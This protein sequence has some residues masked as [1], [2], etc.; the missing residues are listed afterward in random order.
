M[1][2]NKILEVPK[3]SKMSVFTASLIDYLIKA[4][5][6]DVITDDEMTEVCGKDT[7]PNKSGYGNLKS[8]LNYLLNNEG[9]VFERIRGSDAIKC[10]DS[11][12]TV[13]SA[14]GDLKGMH[15]R[16][17]KVRKKTMTVDQTQLSSEDIKRLSAVSAQV[18][19]LELISKRDTFKKL[20]VK[21]LPKHFKPDISKIVWE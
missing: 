8:A 16:A 20:V 14:E 7:R 1:E 21:E 6:G 17:K 4:E 19:F 9:M 3:F 13:I 2:N 5:I 18:G 12:E 11:K 10:L 15:K